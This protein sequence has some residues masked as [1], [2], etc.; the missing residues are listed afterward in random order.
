M[1]KHVK[2]ERAR[3]KGSASDNPLA[4]LYR[5][6]AKARGEFPAIPKNRVAT[7]RMKAGG[8]YS[9]R[10]ADLSDVFN[11]I[12]PILSAYGIA[13]MQYPDGDKLTTVIAHETGGTITTQFPIHLQGGQGHPAQEYQKAITFAKRYA[14]TAALGIATEESIEGTDSRRVTPRA[15]NEGGFNERF[16]SADGNVGVKGVTVP[17]DATPEETARL[18][19]DGIIEQFGNAK[20]A[21]GVNGVWN[22]HDKFIDRF[23]TSYP[24]LYDDVF[25]AFHAALEAF[26]EASE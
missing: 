14:L 6:L 15:E 23:K 26:D 1:N 12:D 3:V 20:T 8:Q 22:R 5:D 19:A 24:A 21:K 16:E 10:Y 7:V 17:K 11:A 13:V 2:F 25:D 4:P 9:Y 18:Y